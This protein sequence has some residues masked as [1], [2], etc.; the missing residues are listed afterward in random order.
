MLEHIA[1]SYDLRSEI[2]TRL[3]STGSRAAKPKDDLIIFFQRHWPESL[4]FLRER[5][6][7]TPF[8]IELDGQIT[9]TPEMAT[10]QVQQFTHLYGGK[11][12]KVP[13][14]FDEAHTRSNILRHYLRQY[15]T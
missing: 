5:Y 10:M 9:G 7:N 13:Y 1:Q 4:I 15:W 14:G 2:L 12:D 6:H 8:H 3:P 11:A